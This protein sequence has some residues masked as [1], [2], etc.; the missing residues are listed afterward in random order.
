MITIVVQQKHQ[1]DG[2][3][4]PA[5]TNLLSNLKRRGRGRRGKVE[6]KEEGEKGARTGTSTWYKAYIQHGTRSK[7]QTD[8][9]K[10]HTAATQPWNANNNGNDNKI[11]SQ[12]KAART[13]MEPR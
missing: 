10:N 1:I 4:S 9:Q 7:R 2:H 13:A 11:K 3:N 12:R 6:R 5:S 8:E